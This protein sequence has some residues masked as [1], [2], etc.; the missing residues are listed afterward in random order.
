MPALKLQDGQLVARDDI[1]DME[2]PDFLPGAPVFHPDDFTPAD[3][4]QGVLL[5]TEFSRP[6]GRPN[7]KKRGKKRK[8]PRQHKDIETNS[9]KLVNVAHAIMAKHFT[10]TPWGWF[11]TDDQI[12]QAE[13]LLSNARATAYVLNNVAYESHCPRRVRIDVYPIE[14]NTK[15]PKF[16]QRIGQMVAEKL[17]GLRML[18]SPH[19]M[20]RYRVCMD[21]IRFLEKI[22]VGKQH[23]LVKEGIAAT[24]KQRKTMVK[25]FG[26]RVSLKV[27]D[28]RT[29]NLR[30]SVR[31]D[32][33]AIDAA[34]RRFLPSWDP[35]LHLNLH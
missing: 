31:L 16:R 25:M 3:L 15:D 29:Q 10:H 12:G 28:P 7:G 33:T 17:I 2:D 23:D 4:R 19:Q 14:W 24:V 34:I 18:Y 1:D 11:C 8:V 26:E 22:V 21:G 9:A 30:K 32:P 35:T 27:I 5:L 20:W 13:E 6:S